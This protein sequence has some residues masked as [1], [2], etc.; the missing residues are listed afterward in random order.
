[1]ASTTAESGLERDAIGLPELLFQSITHMAPAVATA[2]SIG[3]ATAFAGGITPLAVVFAMIA[4]LFTAYS[5][6]Q[7]ARH[8]PSAGGMYTYVGRG[9]GPFLGWLIAWS[10]ALAEPLVVPILL[11]GFGFYGAIFLSTYIG[12]DFQYSWVVLAILC[13]AAVWY[14]TYRGIALSTRTGVVLGVIEIVIF[15][16]ISTL[17]IVNAPQN[18]V[19]VFVPSDGNVLPAFQGMIFCLLAFVGFEAVAPLGEEAK[20]PR[21]TIPRAVI[22]SAV[23][24]G[25]FYVFNYYAATVFFG[26][27]RMTEF[28]TFNNGDPW[29]FMADAVL[30]IGGLLVVLAILNSCLA[31]ANAGATAATRSLF[32]MGRATLIPRWFGAVHPIYRSPVNAVH[33]QAIVGLIV[34][35]VLGFVLADDPFPG[36]GPL[37]VYVWLGTMIG[38]LFAFMYIA[39]NL[40]CIGF[41]LREGRPEFNAIKHVVIPVLGVI[42]MIPAVLA[43]IGGV[44]IPILNVELPPY[45]NS[46]RFTAP[47]VGI[48]LVIGVVAYFVLRSRNPQALARVDDV[49]G[50]DSIATPEGR[51]TI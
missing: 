18:T 41:Y 11:G 13:A 29:G 27:D 39:V 35:L 9:L 31:N 6:S 2:L 30:P 45:E 23:L 22:W 24:V 17:L 26:P 44:T 10:F 47:V 34:A 21:R 51:T 19:S 38:L 42:A 46:L 32:A 28:Y 33:F 15:L 1:M 7:L 48:W 50:G 5:M 14:L 12:I 8:L 40:A 36:S 4:V 20:E 16:L 3:A 43:V 25:L 37:N 49:Y